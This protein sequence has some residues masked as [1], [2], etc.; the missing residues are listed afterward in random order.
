MIISNVDFLTN[1]DLTGLLRKSELYNNSKQVIFRIKLLFYIIIIRM[2]YVTLC[3]LITNRA[4][5]IRND[6]CWNL[7]PI[8]SVI[9][10]QTHILLLYVQL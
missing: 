1:G 10:N 6:L 2:Y 5:R 3:L 4:P 8:P 9:W 7:V